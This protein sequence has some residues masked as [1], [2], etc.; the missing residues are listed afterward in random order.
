MLSKKNVSVH[1][2]CGLGASGV[3][4]GV[5]TKWRRPKINRVETRNRRNGRGTAFAITTARRA[6]TVSLP[7]V[8]FVCQSASFASKQLGARR[9]DG[10]CRPA[11]I[12]VA[13]HPPHACGHLRKVN[14]PSLRA[15][16]RGHEHDRLRS[17]FHQNGAASSR[18]CSPSTDTRLRQ[19]LAPQPQ[20][21]D[22]CSKAGCYGFSG[23]TATETDDV[24]LRRQAL[25]PCPT[26][27]RDAT[28]DARTQRNRP[29]LRR[30]Y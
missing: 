6:T 19:A 22:R 4:P 14:R 11:V 12:E 28:K 13:G 25:P 9:F 23:D 17:T 30:W 7:T 29:W 2:G 20:A 3:I 26:A 8:T 5:L 21:S 18:G 15:R 1:R 24:E 10:G 27:E 16:R